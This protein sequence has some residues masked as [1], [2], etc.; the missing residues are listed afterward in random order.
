MPLEA[1][2]IRG[3][4][5]INVSAAPVAPVAAFTATIRTGTAPLTVRF[6]DQSTNSPTSWK[7]EYRKTDGS[8][9]F[10]GP[11]AQNPTNIFAAGSYDIRLTA[12]NTAGNGISSKTGYI[13][14]AAPVPPTAA[15][16]S[17]VQSGTCPTDNPIHGQ[18][19]RYL[20][21]KLCMGLHE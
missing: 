16:T 19:E 17:S 4:G 6:T 20:S 18:V 5:Y 8:W 15:F 2:L 11:V 12:T 13:I 1:I 9:T 7:W 14:V 21:V 10:S 3:T